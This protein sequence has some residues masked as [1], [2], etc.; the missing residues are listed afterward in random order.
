[1]NPKSHEVNLYRLSDS[2]PFL[3]SLS[4]LDYYSL[5]QKPAA[6]KILAF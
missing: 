5:V 1:M 6:K 2:N 4:A 3:L